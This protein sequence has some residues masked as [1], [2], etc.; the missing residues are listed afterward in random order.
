MN[1]GYQMY[2]SVQIWASFCLGPFTIFGPICFGS[3]F[4]YN[5]AGLSLEHSYEMYIMYK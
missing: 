2:K 3:V 5:W 4:P 1:I